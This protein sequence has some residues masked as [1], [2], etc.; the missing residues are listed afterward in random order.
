MGIISKEHFKTNS[1]ILNFPL[2]VR[3]ELD[4]I[5]TLTLDLHKF[6]EV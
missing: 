2:F 5:Y 4:Y 1:E 3:I 6:Q